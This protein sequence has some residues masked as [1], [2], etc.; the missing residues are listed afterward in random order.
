MSGAVLDT[1]GG[2][3]GFGHKLSLRLF[4]DT[5]C[6]TGTLVDTRG[7]FV[8]RAPPGDYWLTVLDNGREIDARPVSLPAGSFIRDLSLHWTSG[9]RALAMGRR[10]G[11]EAVRS[12][13]R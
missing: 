1:A 7:Q 11:V 3:P 13:S 10:V 4:S 5:G 6:I 12:A 8:I 9:R 2:P